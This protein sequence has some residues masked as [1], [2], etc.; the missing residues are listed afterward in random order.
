LPW[1]KLWGG[2]GR[3]IEVGEE[4]GGDREKRD[5]HVCKRPQKRKEPIT[6]RGKELCGE[7]LSHSQKKSAFKLGWGKEKRGKNAIGENR[8][9]LLI[10]RKIA[11]STTLR[12]F[13]MEVERVVILYFMPKVLRKDP[14][15]KCRWKKEGH[16][17]NCRFIKESLGGKSGVHRLEGEETRIH[18]FGGGRRSSKG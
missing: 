9:K 17:C 8:P 15:K 6:W 18:H 16:S 7:T 13:A 11:R 2:G 12:R 5:H 10:K 1:S 3:Y 4:G 14:R